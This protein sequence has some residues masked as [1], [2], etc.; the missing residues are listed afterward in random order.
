MKK[1]ALPRTLFEMLSSD[2]SRGRGRIKMEEDRLLLEVFEQL[3]EAHESATGKRFSVR[4][5][6]RLWVIEQHVASGLPRA[7]AEQLVDDPG[8]AGRVPFVRRCK[9]LSNRLAGARR[10]LRSPAAN[11]KKR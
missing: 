11:N 5:F 9:T 10:R 6:L 7:K 1:H 3:R 4:A 2:D 8:N